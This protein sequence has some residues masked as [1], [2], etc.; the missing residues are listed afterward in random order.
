MV[1][2]PKP[3]HLQAC[4]SHLGYQPGSLPHTEQAA[5]D[6]LALPIYPELPAE[7]Q[8]RVVQTMAAALGRKGVPLGHVVPRPKFLSIGQRAGLPKQETRRESA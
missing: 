3:L 4:F 7:H 1:Y 2:Y 8:E 5:L 6:S